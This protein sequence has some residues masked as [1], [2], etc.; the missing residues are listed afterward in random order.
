MRNDAAG[1]GATELLA[2]L[3]ERLAPSLKLLSGAAV[4]HTESLYAVERAR[5]DHAI[6]ARRYE[7]STAGG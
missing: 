1:H 3:A 6:A 5:I 4:D 2:H 7:Y